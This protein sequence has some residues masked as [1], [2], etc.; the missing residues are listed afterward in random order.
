[1]SHK[2]DY[3]IRLGDKT[4]GPIGEESLLS[5]NLVHGTPIWFKGLDNWT[6][7]GEIP[8]L[9]HLI[10]IQPPPFVES[11]PSSPPV[12]NPGA[13]QI[14]E[15]ASSGLDRPEAHA[16][17]SNG[18][19][20][21]FLAALLIVVLIIVFAATNRKPG[22]GTSGL[23]ASGQTGS[24][25][26]NVEQDGQVVA[27]EQQDE[28]KAR[29]AALTAKNM[30]YR[31]NWT[32]YIQASRS[33]YSINGLGG[34]SGLTIYITNETEYKLDYVSVFVD[35]ITVN[36]YRHKREYVYFYD[37]KPH[38]RQSM[39]APSTERGSSVE[40]SIGE[41]YAPSFKF[42]FDHFNEIGNGSIK[43]PW[44]CK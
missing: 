7:V 30:E 26:Q 20:Y 12:N 13:A 37:V 23:S 40:Y 41:I 1:M 11:P 25:G 19:L 17:T 10:T 43:D 36:G 4:V 3:Y 8:E 9:V 2:R 27:S 6:T 32:K 18:K 38:T 16:P 39:P 5:Y 24:S 29:I 28:E 44:K 42:C 14:D 21:F 34:I 22:A 31:N 33:G 35:Y 15:R